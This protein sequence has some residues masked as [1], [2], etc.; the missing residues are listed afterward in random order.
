MQGTHANIPHAMLCPQSIPFLEVSDGH[1]H[2]AVLYRP[3]HYPYPT[4]TTV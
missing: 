2:T 4:E 1:E 3:A